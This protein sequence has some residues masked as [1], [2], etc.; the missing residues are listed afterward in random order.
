[1][2]HSNPFAFLVLTSVFLAGCGVGESDFE[3]T[4][5]QKVQVAE[6][7]APVGSVMMAG[8]V[9]MVD[10]GSSETNVQ[11][12]VLSAGSEH[13]VK[14]LNSGD[15][16]NMIFEPAVI[17]VS[18]GDTIHFKAVDMA[19]NSATIE[20]MIPAGASAWASALS[21]DVSITLD[22]E[23]VYVYQCDP[24]AMMAMV[25]VIQVGEAVNM[26]EI[27]ASAEQYKSNFMM[28]A[29]RLSGYLDQL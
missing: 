8:Q 6:R 12:V 14:M 25:G 7:T 26:S 17:K 29:G 5:S 20:G 21:Q 28:N 13:I 10:T 16:G 27:K 9:S 24:H 18:K 4:A 19:H 15:G 23:G 11:K 22:A 3:L 2:S 1:M